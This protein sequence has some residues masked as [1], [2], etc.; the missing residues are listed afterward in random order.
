MIAAALAWVDLDE[1]GKLFLEVAED[2]AV[3]A[4]N[5]LHAV[6][7]KD[8]KT[9]ES[10]TLNNENVREAIAS[11]VSLVADNPRHEVTLR[12]FTTASIG[13]EKAIADRPNGEAGLKYWRRAAAASDVSPIRAHLVSD[14]FPEAVREFVRVRDDE[15]LRRDLLRRIH[16]DCGNPD[17]SSLRQELE[18]RLVVLGRDKFNLPAAET[19]QLADILIYQALQRSIQ[20]GSAQRVLTRAELYNTIDRAK[21]RFVPL[22]S[23]SAYQTL[24]SAVAQKVPGADGTC[25]WPS[26]SQGGLLEAKR[27]QTARVWFRA[28]RSKQKFKRLCGAMAPVLLWGPAGCQGKS[29]LADVVAASVSDTF[30]IA[31][32]RDAY[33]ERCAHPFGRAVSSSCGIRRQSLNFRRPQSA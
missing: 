33:P 26:Q 9:S 25:N 19:V 31:D 10:A 23:L 6:Q 24:A 12:Y 29:S 11:F 16:W 28:K 13:T 7:V 27:C 8:T 17:I 4:S 22:T 21:G 2:Y 1:K 30:V 5:N 32:F 15:A 14:K 20:K 18:D 3:I